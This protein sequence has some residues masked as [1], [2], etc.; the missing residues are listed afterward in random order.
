MTARFELGIV[1]PNMQYGPARTTASWPE[2]RALAARAEAIGVDTIR[3]A[4]ELL[5]RLEAGAPSG[6]CDGGS[7]AGAVAVVT[8]KAKVGSWVLSALHRTPAIIAKP[9]ETL[10]ELSG[11]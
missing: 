1:L 10:D 4:D 2:I 6:R 7:L 11:G 9:A 5:F 8:S 3:S